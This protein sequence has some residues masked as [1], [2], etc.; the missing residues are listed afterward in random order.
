MSLIGVSSRETRMKVSTSNCHHLDN[1]SVLAQTIRSLHNIAYFKSVFLAIFDSCLQYNSVSYTIVY[2]PCFEEVYLNI[3]NQSDCFC[4]TSFLKARFYCT[5]PLL[6]SREI[7]CGHFWKWADE[8]ASL[9]IDLWLTC[10]RTSR[11]EPQQ[12]ASL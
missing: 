11:A 9:N 5:A 2:T 12:A 8:V 1:L 3:R 10:R 6:L 4:E 7:S